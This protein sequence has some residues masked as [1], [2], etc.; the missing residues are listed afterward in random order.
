MLSRFRGPRNVEEAGSLES[1]DQRSKHYKFKFTPI[2]IKAG[3]AVSVIRDKDGIQTIHEGPYVFRPYYAV[4][5]ILRRITCD[6]QHY[7]VIRSI[8]GHLEHRRG[9]ASVYFNPCIYESITIE[10]AITL[11]A[12]Q[13]IVVYKENSVDSSE[14]SENVVAKANKST[15]VSRRVVSGPDIFVPEPNEWLHEFSWHGTK[16]SGQTKGSITGFPGDTKTAHAVEFTK[17]RKL[18]DQMYY[19]VK[20]L[21]TK[22]DA[23]LTL[24][25]MIFFELVD[26]EKML[27]ATNDPIS[28][29]INSVNADIMTFAAERTYEA[30]LAESNQLSNNSTYKILG[31]RMNTVGYILNKVVYRGYQT[32]SALQ[33]MHD[34]AITAR[35]Q[36][37]LDAD[38]NKQEQINKMS[39]LKARQEQ[40]KL[41]FDQQEKEANLRRKLAQQEVEY[42]AKMA[43]LKLDDEMAAEKIKFDHEIAVNS[44]SNELQ[45]LHM[46]N[47]NNERQIFLHGLVEKGVD[48]T[49]YLVAEV[50]SKPTTHMLFESAGEGSD[51]RTPSLHFHDIK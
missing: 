25:I 49:K 29:M 27:D 8:N 6:T 36:L 41:E 17:L 48:L 35:T 20:E 23:L 42:E 31:A 15:H 22:D 24:N 7:L 43:K 11:E 32:S 2:V 21:R 3:E 34:K 4:V 39:N 14:S 47:V 46:K 12:A 33:S 26:I 18:P 1:K 50:G 16:I 28:D 45:L 9:P 44:K 51:T 5:D 19:T 38:R 30:L 10:K 37:R 13:N 40:A